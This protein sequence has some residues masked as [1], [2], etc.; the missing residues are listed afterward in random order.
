MVESDTKELPVVSQKLHHISRK[1]RTND[2]TDFVT[3]NP[4]VSAKKAALFVLLEDQ[5]F[6]H[7]VKLREFCWEIQQPRRASPSY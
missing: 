3:E 4:L 6:L 2:A 7:G 1:R 5:L